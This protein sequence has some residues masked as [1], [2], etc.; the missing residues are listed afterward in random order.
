[1]F[2][3]HKTGPG[4]Y[5]ATLKGK[6]EKLSRQECNLL[7]HEL[8]QVIRT[9]REI[10]VN[11]NGVNSI[12]KEGYKILGDVMQYSDSKRCKIRF[13]QVGPLI[14]SSIKKLTTKKTELHNEPESTG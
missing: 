12:D 3:I 4:Y 5:L 7:K 11:L 8:Y 6:S 14:S 10:S 9:N 1:M 13:I 2:S